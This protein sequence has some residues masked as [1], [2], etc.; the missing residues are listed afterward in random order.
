MPEMMPYDVYYALND[1]SLLI[2]TKVKCYYSIL[3]YSYNIESNHKFWLLWSWVKITGKTGLGLEDPKLLF[4]H[5][6]CYS[7]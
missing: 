3:Q 2:P 6:S 1:A 5:I 4:V 7:L